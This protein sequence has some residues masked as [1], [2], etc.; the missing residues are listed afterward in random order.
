MQGVAPGGA[1]GGAQSVESLSPALG[2]K[3]R[4][5]HEYD[6]GGALQHLAAWDG[7]RGYIMG[8]YESSI[9]AFPRFCQG[10]ATTQ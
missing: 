2:R 7:Q 3:R 1:Q 9:L 10:V 8:R 6:R 4:I 5:E